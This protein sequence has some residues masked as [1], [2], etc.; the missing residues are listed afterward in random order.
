MKTKS[1]FFLLIRKLFQNN[2]KNSKIKARKTKEGSPKFMKKYELLIFDLDDTLINNNENVRYAFKK[3]TEVLGYTYS[4][5][6]FNEWQKFDKKFW[7][8]FYNG[9]IEIPYNKDDERFVPYVQSLRYRNFFR[10][11]ISMERALEINPK[12]IDWLKEIVVPE[13]GCYE[14]LAYLHQKGY[15][16]VVAT[17]GANQAIESKLRKINCRQFIDETF[18]ADMTKERVTKPSPIYFKEL[19]D[20]LDYH[21]KEK[22]LLIGDS[23]HSEVQGGKNAGIDTCWY[24]KEQNIAPEDCTPTIEIHKLK[25]LTKKL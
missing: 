12:F 13:E 9:K 20:Y 11:Q 16:L 17:N 10:P 23:L 5:E 21:E 19:L 25:E 7:L 14:T 1:S 24:N 3:M 4:D 8:D 6:M 15:R 22:I 2:N 18:S